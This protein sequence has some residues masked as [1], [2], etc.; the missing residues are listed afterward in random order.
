MSSIIDHKCSKYQTDPS[1]IP[2]FR[3]CPQRHAG[4]GI[5][6]DTIGF[7]MNMDYPAW[8]NG[9][10]C[11]AADLVLSAAD[12]GFVFAATLTDSCR[13]YGHRLFRW[14]EHLRRLRRDSAACR[15]LL[16]YSDAE[17]TAAA[18]GL[19][20][21][22]RPTL[23]ATEDVMVT[24][25]VTPGPL[26]HLSGSSSPPTP[27]VGMQLRPLGKERYR[28]FF[29]EGVTL[30][31]AGVWPADANS[32]LPAN[33]K[34]RSRLHWWLADQT[35]R[36]PAGSCY[37]PTAIAVLV[38]SLGGRPDTALGSILA[39]ENDTVICVP[40]GT[41]QDSI[42][43]EVVREL[44]DRHGIPLRED[45]IRFNSVSELMLAGSGF[46]LAGVSRWISGGHSREFPW[47]GP[48]TARLLSAWSEHVGLDH[49]Q[50]FRE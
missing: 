17:L 24:T 40:C 47:P 9:T 43:V 19:V 6:I 20:E 16:P 11:P 34:H 29:T 35:I 41:V 15:V 12:A 42:S 26:P 36:D 32:I 22:Q 5:C 39:V 14:P 18:E 45:R 30:A 23:A 2:E 3:G 7:A 8:L 46:G 49:V 13:T 1:E 48:V 27:T 44:C 37:A 25:F 50:Q 31:V 21:S 4:S 28:R 33:V 10:V 38:D